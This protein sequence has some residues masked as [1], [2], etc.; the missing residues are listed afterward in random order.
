MNDQLLQDRVQ[1]AIEKVEEATKAAQR[2]EDA[3]KSVTQL[4]S[5]LNSA[6]LAVT[7]ASA[8][9]NATVP[10]MHD[11]LR[12]LSALTDVV[13]AA[14]P[15]RI[16]EQICVLAG[17][18]DTVG[19]DARS[20]ASKSQIALVQIEDFK[21]KLEET[22]HAIASA[23]NAARDDLKRIQEATSKENIS[24]LT[25]IQSDVKT[26]KTIAI[27]TLLCAL[28][29]ATVALIALVKGWI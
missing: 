1:K 27:V 21:P 7:N 16:V 11:A 9:V 14:G 22:S 25:T 29:S 3:E 12:A 17:I 8:V 13:R 6:A 19:S 24:A 2:L 10:V 26:L 4:S 23:V 20:A 15:E 5:T 18:V 28:V